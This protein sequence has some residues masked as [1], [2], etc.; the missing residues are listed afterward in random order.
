M[1]HKFQYIGEIC[2]FRKTGNVAD[3]PRSGPRRRA[4][5]EDTSATILAAII[6]S[7]ICQI[8]ECL[9]LLC[10][11]TY[12]PPCITVQNFLFCPKIVRFSQ[13]KFLIGFCSFC[14]HLGPYS[15]NTVFTNINKVSNSST[16][17]SHYDNMLLK[18]KA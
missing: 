4:T 9:F 2:K 14:K 1:G 5:N 18:S 8:F 15:Y 12:G 17:N 3:Q 16:L 6:W 11:E 7:P 10:I 13:K